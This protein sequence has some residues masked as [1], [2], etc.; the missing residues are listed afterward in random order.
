M[1]LNLRHL[2]KALGHTSR[3]RHLHSARPAAAILVACPA[4]FPHANRANGRKSGMQPRHRR[5]ANRQRELHE[6]RQ[7]R[8]PD[9]VGRE[10]VLLEDQLQCQRSWC[11]ISGW[12]TTL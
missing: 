4:H 9:K 1:S 12:L 6:R 5:H 10:E 11:R 2:A 8:K 3:K 7:V